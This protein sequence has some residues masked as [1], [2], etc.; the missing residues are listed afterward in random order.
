MKTLDRF[1]GPRISVD[2]DRCEVYGICVWE[3]PALF[4][5]DRDGRLRYRRQLEDADFAQAAAAARCCPMQAIVL[6]GM[7]DE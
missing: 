4:Q 2:N 6:R 3:A 1:R 7:S 5:L